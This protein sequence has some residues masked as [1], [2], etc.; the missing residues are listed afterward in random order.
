MIDNPCSF[1][2]HIFIQLADLTIKK[3]KKKKT[4]DLDA[5]LGEGHDEFMETTAAP[6][7][8]NLEPS[9]ANEDFDG[10]FNFIL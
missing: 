5:A 2:I 10:S 6:D 4:F 7:K 9:A 3:K 8:E 1:Y